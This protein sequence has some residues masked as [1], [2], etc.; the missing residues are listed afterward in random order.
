MKR[1]KKKRTKKRTTTSSSRNYS[2]HN[3]H[4]TAHFVFGTAG[5]GCHMARPDDPTTSAW[6]L[7]WETVDLQ[8]YQGLSVPDVALDDDVL[9]VCNLRTDQHVTAYVTVYD[10]TLYGRSMGRHQRTPL[11]TGT[12]TSEEDGS[13]RTCTT[14]IVLCPPL[15]M[16]RLCTL[17]QPPSPSSSPEDWPLKSDVQVWTPHLHPDDEHTRCIGFPLLCRGDNH[18]KGGSDSNICND[19]NLPT[20][21]LCTQSEGGV[22]TH[23]FAGNYHALDFACPVGTPLLAVADGVV[24]EAHA[25]YQRV[26]GIDVANL[27]QWNAIMLRV[28]NDDNN[29]LFVEYVH[30]ATTSVQTGDR[31]TVGQVIGTSGSIGFSPEPHLH[32]AAYRSANPQAST[33]RVR[34]QKASEPDQT[35]LPKAGQYYNS[36]GV[37]EG[38]K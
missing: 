3:H 9:C 33:V 29:P 19:Q 10:Q 18:G 6:V 34:F 37:A 25:R 13:T 32:L 12:A 8:D 26:S 36:N 30:I 14:L 22:L 24:V 20:S 21:Y 31:V 11:Q 16:A 17:E 4:D 28:D 7:G 27:F 38:Q 15:T 2:Q 1:T 23:F 35:F 5:Q